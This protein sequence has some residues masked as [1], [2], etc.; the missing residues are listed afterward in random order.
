M[1][2]AAQPYLPFAD[3]ARALEFG[4][5]TRYHVAVDAELLCQLATR[6]AWL[7]LHCLQHLLCLTLAQ[8]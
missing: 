2:Y 8:P 7:V 5:A 6:A 3:D 4:E 1:P